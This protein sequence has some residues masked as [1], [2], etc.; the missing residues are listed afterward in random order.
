M[1]EQLR[2]ISHCCADPL[3]TVDGILDIVKK[4]QV[5]EINKGRRYHSQYHYLFPLLKQHS[6]KF[7]IYMRMKVSTF[8]Y[9]LSK[10]EEP[11][12]K[13]WCNL[14]TEPILPEE[15]LVI[16]THTHT[17]THPYRHFLKSRDLN[18]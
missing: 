11:L 16:T 12:T 9:I 14:H 17:H 8:D 10:L 18:F 6:D 15:K 1:E 3:G 13:N 5:H 2:E 7:E 4:K